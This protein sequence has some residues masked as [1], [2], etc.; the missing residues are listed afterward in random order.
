MLIN[1]G[2]I[3]KSFQYR[4]SVLSNIRKF[5]SSMDSIKSLSLINSEKNNLTFIATPTPNIVSKVPANSISFSN[6]AHVQ[7]FQ[8][9]KKTSLPAKIL[10]TVDNSEIDLAK[11]I[12]DSNLN[13]TYVFTYRFS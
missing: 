10:P 1:E 4:P 9:Q 8:E 11:L 5:C 2:Q 6:R 7:A 12:R 3:G 13:N